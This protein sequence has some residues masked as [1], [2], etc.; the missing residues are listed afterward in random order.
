MW[1]G[2]YD[3]PILMKELLDMKNIY[4]N[5]SINEVNSPTKEVVFFADERGYARLF[6]ASPQLNGI[7]QTRLAMGN[8]G[9]PYDIYTVEDAESILGNYKVAVFPMP[10]SSE[11]GNKAKEL[12]GKMGI[13]YLSA[14]TDHCA[15]TIAELKDFYKSHGIHFYS[16]ENDVVY[17]GNGYIGLHSSTAGRKRLILPEH[18]SISAIFGA[19]TFETINGSIE[20]DL[21]ENQTAL[22]FISK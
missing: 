5:K 19:N 21:K 11:A 3:D 7:H 13:P 4:S 6:S 1:G 16:E 18:H 2:W 17:L 22:F 14:T 8:T 10:T 20:F 12:C 9:V 15:L